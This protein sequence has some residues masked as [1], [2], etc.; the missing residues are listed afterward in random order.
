M[1]TETVEVDKALF[2][3]LSAFSAAAAE[4]K[5][6]WLVIGATARIMLLEQIYAWPQGIGTQDIDFAVQVGDW[7]HYKLLCEYITKADVYAAERK[8]AKRFRSKEDTVFDLVPYGGVENEAKQVFWPPDNDD[9]MTV[10]GFE[11][12]AK[13]AVSVIVNQK[14]KIRVV[15]PRG[16]CALKFFAW[17]ERHRQHPGRDAKDIAYLFKHI[18]SL[19]PPDK[20]FGDHPRAVEVADYK[21]QNAGYYQLGFDVAELIA[22][23]D[24]TFL[25][26]LLAIEL[27]D[28]EDSVLCRE[29]H[30]YTDM[31]TL[32]ETR[33]ALHYFYKGLEHA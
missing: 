7:E 33:N 8:P 21:I 27:K 15:S 10:R 30:K 31:Q 16:L 13:D 4:V 22:E 5:A 20:L 19:Y 26:E 2:E 9:V 24:Q 3:V 17:E 28:N 29:L 1:K 11:S 23:E 18:E 12:A 32:E 14:L 6:P 25:N